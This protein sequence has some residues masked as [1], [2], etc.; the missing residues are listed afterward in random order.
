[1]TQNTPENTTPAPA[2]APQQKTE[3]KP[4]NPLDVFRKGDTEVTGNGEVTPEMRVTAWNEGY[5]VID[6]KKNGDW[7]VSLREQ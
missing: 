1:M 5:G 4:D 7:K 2:P 6:S 3:A